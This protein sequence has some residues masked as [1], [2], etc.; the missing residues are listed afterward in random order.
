MQITHTRRPTTSPTMTYR[1]PV[2]HGWAALPA[3]TREYGGLTP[4]PFGFRADVHIGAAR[5]IGDQAARELAAVLADC[6]DY[7]V[8]GTNPYGLAIVAG[9]LAVL[10]GR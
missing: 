10:L 5:D 2:W 9:R 6:S 7:Q 3:P 8:H 4:V 1:L